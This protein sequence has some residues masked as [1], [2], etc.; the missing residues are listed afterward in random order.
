M[1]GWECA[2]A[3]MQG[4]GT[5]QQAV[6]RVAQGVLG[7]R[8]FPFFS[9]TKSNKESFEK[10]EKDDKEASKG[11]ANSPLCGTS[12]SKRAAAA[13][14]R[15]HRIYATS[16]DEPSKTPRWRCIGGLDPRMNLIVYILMI[17]RHR[18]RYP[19]YLYT[20]RPRD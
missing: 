6:S 18:S 5:P 2:S 7:P 20:N 11:K 10:R 19:E 1:Q 4:V 13:E 17:L 3:A 12:V 14:N 8:Y 9:M 16:I 15:S